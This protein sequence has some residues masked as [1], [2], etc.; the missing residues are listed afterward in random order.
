MKI[1]P[2]I[3][4]LDPVACCSKQSREAVVNA[5]LRAVVNPLRTLP[6][7]TLIPFQATTCT[8]EHLLA[9][10]G[11]LASALSVRVL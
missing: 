6:H 3:Y 9:F 8:I 4:D 2:H 7:K 11:D 10:T 5:E 1:L